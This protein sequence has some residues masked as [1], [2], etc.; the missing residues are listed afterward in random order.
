MVPRSL[1]STMSQDVTHV[2]ADDVHETHATNFQLAGSEKEVILSAGEIQIE[3]R[4]DGNA[5]ADTVVYDTKIRMD[6]QT[7]LELRNMLTESLEVEVPDAD[8]SGRGVQ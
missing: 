8:P 4:S 6:H 7:A 1:H 2:E 5:D 3:V